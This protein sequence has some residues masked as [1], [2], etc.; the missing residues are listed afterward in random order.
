MSKRFLNPGTSRIR[1][2]AILTSAH[3]FLSAGCEVITILRKW[4]GYVAGTSAL[5]WMIGCG[6]SG[7]GGDTT[8][9]ATTA[10]TGSTSTATTATTGSTSTATTATTGSTATGTTSGTPSVTIGQ[11][12][13]F[14]Q[15][16]P[17]ISFFF[18]T[19]QGRAPDPVIAT[20]HRVAVSKTG[21]ATFAEPLAAAIN[22]Q[23]NG[24]FTQL[25]NVDVTP[26][27]GTGASY[28]FDSYNLNIDSMQFGT[29]VISNQNGDAVVQDFIPA[30]I[31]VRPG[32][33]TIV[34]LFIDDSMFA[35][36]GSTVTYNRDALIARNV[37]PDTGAIDGFLSDYVRFDISGI[38]NKPLLSDGTP[39]SRIYFSGDNIALSA[40]GTSGLF[41][42]LDPSV[43]NSGH[44]DPPVDIAGTLTPGTYTVLQ[45]DPRPVSALAKI[46]SLQGIYREYTDVTKN[47]G[48]FNVIVFPDSF[49]NLDSYDLVM[50]SRDA[51]GVIT[52]MYFG[53]ADLKG[54]IFSAFPL[55]DLIDGS[56]TGE[57]DGTLTG[58]L[59]A[60]G[61]ATTTPSAVRIGT[62]NITSGTVDPNFKSTGQFFVFSQ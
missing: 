16:D 22:L 31:R 42:V 36:G 3:Q 40:G 6:G 61:N 12:L 52:Q 49:D 14:K 38:P 50:F 43:I 51:N 32:R 18:L 1:Q 28:L 54:N 56:T 4:I 47:L 13:N 27:P 21:G 41:N 8:S 9:T 29:H 59:D 2:L 11:F 62:I 35:D 25:K 46:A 26:Y 57:I 19:G 53:A 15:N 10:T 45:D 60:N 5:V 30:N 39:A 33:Q 17:F 48:S 55:T 34:P 24:Y 20:L 44:F 37:D 7:L 23:L 58:L